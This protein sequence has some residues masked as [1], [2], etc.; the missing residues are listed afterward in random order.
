MWLPLKVL[1]IP[2]D[3]VGVFSR[4]YENAKNWFMDKNTKHFFFQFTEKVNF[5]GALCLKIRSRFLKSWNISKTS[6]LAIQKTKISFI[7]YHTKFICLN[8]FRIHHLGVYNWSECQLSLLFILIIVKSCFPITYN[9][10]N[11][12]I[13]S[14]YQVYLTLK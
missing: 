13:S 14:I 10:K 5:W 2:P 1:F 12:N 9:N 3:P 11:I 4:I 7:F 8:C 6:Y